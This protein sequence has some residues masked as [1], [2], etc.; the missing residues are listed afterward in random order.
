M[1]EIYCEHSTSSGGG[2]DDG[3]RGCA[4]GIFEAD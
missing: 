3:L 2:R 4:A 1:T